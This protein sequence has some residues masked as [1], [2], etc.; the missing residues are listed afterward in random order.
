MVQNSL[1][2]I[3]VCS[4]FCKYFRHRHIISITCSSLFSLKSPPKCICIPNHHTVHVKYIQLYL[5]INKVKVKPICSWWSM[6]KQSMSWTGKVLDTMLIPVLGGE[7]GEKLVY[8]Q[9]AWTLLVTAFL[10][11]EDLLPS[12]I[13]HLHDWQID[14]QSQLFLVWNTKKKCVCLCVTYILC[15][16]VCVLLT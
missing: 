11:W 5:S 10:R 12:S 1:F 9:S 16:C 7:V 2:L 15:V 14:L 8:G 4:I 6:Q 13:L 3:E